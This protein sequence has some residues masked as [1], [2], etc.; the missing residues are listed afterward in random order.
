M[1]NST[2]QRSRIVR[3]AS[4]RAMLQLIVTDPAFALDVPCITKLATANCHNQFSTVMVCNIL[5]PCEFYKNLIQKIKKKPDA[6]RMNS[7]KH[8]N[9]TPSTNPQTPNN[10]SYANVVKNNRND[11]MLSDLVNYFKIAESIK[12]EY[13]SLKTIHENQALL[14]KTVLDITLNNYNG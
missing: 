9:P 12:Q 6:P 13:N 3:T 4:N 1:K 5:K 14:I 2:I 11:P 10:A 8:I 7:A